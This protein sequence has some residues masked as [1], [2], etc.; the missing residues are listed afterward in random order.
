MLKGYTKNG[1]RI[2]GTYDLIPATA[3]LQGRSE[4]GELIYSGY[5]EV[6]WDASEAQREI[7]QIIFV[8]ETYGHV[9]ESHIDW[10]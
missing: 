2:I 10:R 6:V 5:S 3:L 1:K 8:D 4:D 9:L 7:G